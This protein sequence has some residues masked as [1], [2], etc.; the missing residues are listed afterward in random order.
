MTKSTLYFTPA[1]VFCIHNAEEALFAPR[2]LEFL[3]TRAPDFLR[4]FYSDIEVSQLR[5]G[6]AFL[7]A[8]G[9]LLALAAARRPTSAGWAYAMLVFAGVI[10]INGLAHV[11]LSFVARAYLPGLVTAVALSLPT[12]ALLHR[13]A[14]REH[15]IERPAF[16]SVLPVAVLVHGPVLMAFIRLVVVRT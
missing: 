8:F 6:L 13:V 9:V 14:W 5:V 4:A 7:S 11:L 3:Q 12:A 2:M 15:W 1:V 16:A 10:G